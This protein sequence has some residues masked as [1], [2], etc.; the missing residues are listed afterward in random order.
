MILLLF[1]WSVSI[2]YCIV[3]HNMSLSSFEQKHNIYFIRI[4]SHHDILI[5][6][7]RLSIMLKTSIEPQYF[8]RYR[9]KYVCIQVSK[10]GIACLSGHICSVVYLFC[11]QIVSDLNAYIYQYQTPFLFR[12]SYCVAADYI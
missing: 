4:Y 5:A 12:Q 10:V 11:D 3:K 8:F 9:P 1:F 2:Y 7:L 6:H